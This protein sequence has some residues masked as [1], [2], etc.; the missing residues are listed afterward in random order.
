VKR[1]RLGLL[2][3]APYLRND[4]HD[5]KEI[6]AGKYG[7]DPVKQRYHLRF[8]LSIHFPENGQQYEQV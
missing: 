3:R 7:F 8:S 5:E 6:V 2:P 1:G 4:R